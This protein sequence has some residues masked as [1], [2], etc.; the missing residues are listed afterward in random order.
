[1]DSSLLHRCLTCV[2]VM[3]AAMTGTSFLP[4]SAQVPTG[5]V[6]IEPGSVN[7]P[8]LGARPQSPD[9]PRIPPNL[10]PYQTEAYRKEY[11]EYQTCTREKGREM[12]L[13]KTSENL[14]QLRDRREFW[15]SMHERNA[16][17][18]HPNQYIPP[19][20]S[21]GQMLATSFAEYRS[22]GGTAATVDGVRLLPPP[23]IH[24]L[25]KP[26]GPSIPLTDT[27]QKVIP[28]K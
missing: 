2:A 25:S 11:A 15:E 21:Y 9:E 10:T 18:K 28:S 6:Q 23:C 5:P 22:L 20:G 7:R 4:A 17:Q 27:R 14:I 24:P 13:S 3:L 8:P 16:K 26:R 1:M 12:Q 19:P